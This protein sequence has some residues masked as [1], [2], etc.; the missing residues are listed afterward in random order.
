[1]RVTLIEVWG[2]GV[3]GWGLGVGGV[4]RTKLPPTS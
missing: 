3:G 4:G 2:L 1:L